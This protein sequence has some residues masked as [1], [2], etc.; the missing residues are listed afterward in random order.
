[1]T[2]TQIKGRLMRW[3]HS[4]LMFAALMIGHHFSISA[5]LEGG[6][7]LRRLLLA[8]RDHVAEIGKPRARGGIGEHIDHRGIELGD[9]VRRRPLGCKNANQLG[10]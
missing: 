3:P 4:T 10:T 1:M 9:D 7:R 8:R 6:E 2:I 5:L